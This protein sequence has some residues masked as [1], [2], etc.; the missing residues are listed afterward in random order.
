MNGLVENTKKLCDI[1]SDNQ[2]YFLHFNLSRF[3][4]IVIVNYKRINL[5]YDKFIE[6]ALLISS[7][8]IKNVS[9]YAIDVLTISIMIL[10]NLIKDENFFPQKDLF[11]SLLTI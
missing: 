10:L 2:I 1:Q 7:K 5:V 9:H 6:I 3:L 8:L 4:E 11:S